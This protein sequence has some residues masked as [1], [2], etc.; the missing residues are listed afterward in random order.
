VHGRIE[1][2]AHAPCEGEDPEGKGRHANSIA[3]AVRC[4]D[5]GVRHQFNGRLALLARRVSGSWAERDSGSLVE[6]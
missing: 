1:G 6:P 3:L 4:A 5:L 2:A